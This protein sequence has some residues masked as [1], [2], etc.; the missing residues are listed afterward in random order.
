MRYHVKLPPTHGKFWRGSWWRGYEQQLGET[1]ETIRNRRN[2]YTS[3]TTTFCHAHAR[4]WN[5]ASKPES[6]QGVV[7]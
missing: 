4:L 2:G 3:A 5:A 1:G 7:F 6:E